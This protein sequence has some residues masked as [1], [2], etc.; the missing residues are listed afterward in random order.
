VNS[1]L[2]SL[3]RR[4]GERKVLVTG[5]SGRIGK[6]LLE[7]LLAGGVTPRALYRS[8]PEISPQGLQVVT[9][10]LLRPESLPAVLRDVDVVWHLASHAPA[11]D[12]PRP[13][14]H[15][16][17]REVTV[18]GTRNLLAAA[19]AAGVSRLIFASSTRVLDGSSSLY[20]RSKKEAESLVR[21][22]EAFMETVILR[23]APV[24]GFSAQGNVALMMAA[25]DAGRFPSLPEFGERRSLVHVD[26]VVQALL[27]SAV[28]AGMAGKTYT[29]TDLQSYS[30]RQM[31]EMI[32]AALGR[33]PARR[34]LPPWLLGVAAGAGELL[35]RL[36]GRPVPMNRERLRKLRASAWFDG[37]PLAREAG[38]Q[39]Q[40]DLQG[41][42]PEIVARY[43]SNS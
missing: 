38:Y 12:D 36:S 22:E 28:E 23:L 7:V 3:C 34:V 4:L 39:P 1:H 16:R 15:P 13:E 17:H 33:Q 6:R 30:S 43:R 19:R 8:P 24:Y 26:D 18:E 11:R 21:R 20:A 25:I 37:E 14:E 40:W 2:D 35:Q 27:L 32:C 42:L 9:G 29:V 5:A 31:Y 41:A 10:D